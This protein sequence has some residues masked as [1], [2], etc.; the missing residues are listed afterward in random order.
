M[1]SA[2]PFTMPAGRCIDERPTKC[3]AA[4]LIKTSGKSDVQVREIRR[5]YDFVETAVIVPENR[6]RIKHG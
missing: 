3:I 2:E 1:G 4:E 6:N 5:K